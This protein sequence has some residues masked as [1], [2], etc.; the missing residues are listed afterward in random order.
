ME[1]LCFELAATY[2]EA[3][4]FTFLRLPPYLVAGR[5]RVSWRG[6]PGPGLLL[7]GVEWSDD[8]ASQE[9]RGSCDGG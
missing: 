9:E 4:G 1:G 5:R 7:A 8:G 3:N 2:K 6:P